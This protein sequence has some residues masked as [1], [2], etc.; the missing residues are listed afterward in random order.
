MSTP[1]PPREREEEGSLPSLR[2]MKYDASRYLKEKNV[3]LVD[4]VA[5]GKDVEH[6]RDIVL[7]PEE[8]PQRSAV[9]LLTWIVIAAFL[10]VGGYAAYVFLQP[11]PPSQVAAQPPKAY[12]LL[13][14]KEIITVRAGDRAGLLDKLRA[15]RRDQFPSGSIKQII[16]QVESLNGQTH[17][18][19]LAEFFQILDMR[20]PAALTSYMEESFN[21]LLYYTP[22]RG[23]IAIL[24]EIRNA[25]GV[26]AQMFGWEQD[27]I[28]DFRNFYFDEEIIATAK[29]F[30]DHI[31]KNIDVRTLP[32]SPTATLSYALFGR[33]YIMIA[34]TQEFTELLINRLLAAPPIR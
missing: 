18:A 2:T 29:L 5:Q 34:T 3:S 32:I 30:E 28:L 19:T 10:G 26:L 8:E 25:E 24:A 1:P 9:K 15:V 33:R 14:S 11:P 16:I 23:D 22:T 12:V 7:A 17:Y 20:A 4:L 31:I 21:L 13:E 6:E 27:M